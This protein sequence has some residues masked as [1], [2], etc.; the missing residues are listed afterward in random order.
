M[1]NNKTSLTLPSICVIG[2]IHGHLQ[3][4][5]C[6][7]ARWQDEL[8][9]KFDAVLLCGDVGT[10]TDDSQLDN[11]TR[12]HAQA[13]PCELEFL[14]QWSV[15][16]QP[17]WLQRIFRPVE[18]DGCGLECPVVMVHGNHEGFAYLAKLI[19]SR[20]PNKSVPIADLP[21][22]DSGGHIRYLP[23][24]WHC[25]TPR[26]ILVGGVGGI[27]RGQR[28]SDYHPLAY[29]D[30][31]AVLHLADGPKL[32]ILITHPGPGSTQ[33]D[34]GAPSLEVLLDA[35]IAKVWFHGHTIRNPAIAT[36]GRVGSM[37][38]VPLGDVAFPGKGSGADDPGEDAWARVCFEPSL[39]V[40]RKRPDCWREFRR[41]RWLRQTDG[42]LVCPT[43]V[44]HGGIG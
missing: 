35:R 43:L 24:G 33:G 9:V 28:R 7:A 34:G 37:T 2:D 8:V 32:D 42:Q 1:E 39:F 5:L 14:H 12:R 10:F 16:P 27:E 41:R 30:E 15:D 22:V 25:L 11:A 36:G 26:G 20:F 17:E 4:G 19:P 38:I 21:T 3:L 23:S 44:R 31:E 18:H 40:E 29:V 13:N 6:L